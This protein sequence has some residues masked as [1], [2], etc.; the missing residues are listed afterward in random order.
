MKAVKRIGD[1]SGIGFEQDLR[2][3]LESVHSD[4]LDRHLR[5]VAS[6]QGPEVEVEGERFLNF[7][8]NDYLGLASSPILR[9]AAL[10][11][12][13]QYGTGSGA[14]RL[15]SGSLKV[16]HDLEG[17]LAA[18]K[19]TPA[20]LTFSSGYAA[21]VGTL[22]ALV[23]RDDLVVLDRLAHASLVDGA[24]LCGAKLRVFEHN[25]CE[26]LERALKQHHATANRRTAK[27]SRVLVVTES[28]FSMDGD[29]APLRELVEV[30]ER[31]GAWLMV[32]EAHATGVMG[33]ERRG[34]VGELGL[35][36][37]V[38]VQMGTLG[39]ALGAG[40][41]YIAGSARLIDWL[42]N[43]ARSFVF[44]TAPVPA[45]AAAAHAGVDCVQSM[46]GR[47]RCELLWER[48][49]EVRQAVASAGW[50]MPREP[51]PIL[52]LIVGDERVAVSCAQAL[53]RR[54]VYAPAIRYP[55]VGR[56]AARLRVT[57]SAL[58]K[59]EQVARLAEALAAAR[60]ESL[61]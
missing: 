9:R 24:R 12:M 42:L 14:S 28:L 49:K 17:A 7:S 41:G 33:R 46:E 15:I 34:L 2:E 1:N 13:K 60:Q 36:D 43:R 29:V 39:K 54:G 16:H 47:H 44:S 21:A 51:S 20:A 11:A 58:H 59:S 27:S 40:G 5:C 56:G 48:V 19:A 18:F 4:G 32:D 22:G 61:E 31:Y 38:E 57:V 6:A 45:L 3:R 8:S 10:Q 52:P 53:Q 23:G 25:D 50:A 30:K 26:S 55:S 37:R 35:G